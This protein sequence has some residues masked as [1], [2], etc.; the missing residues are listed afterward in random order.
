[1]VKQADRMS[2][3]ETN[4][5]IGE[6]QYIS[7]QKIYNGVTI[8]SGSEDF[9][10]KVMDWNAKGKNWM[11][12]NKAKGFLFNDLPE[13]TPEQIQY[14]K[15]FAKAYIVFE[16]MNILSGG[17]FDHDKH[18]AQL[19]VD[20]ETNQVGVFDTGA[21]A[22]VTPKPEEQKLLGHVIYDVIKSN[23]K[24]QGSF[25]S[26]SHIIS[27]KID[28]LYKNG[29]NTQYLVEVKKGLLALG[30]FFKILDNEDIE[31][32]FPGL[33]ILDQVSAPIREGIEEKMTFGER[34]KLRVVAS[35]ALP[36]K[37]N[38]VRIIRKHV[39]SVSDSVIKVDIEATTQDKSSWLQQAFVESDND[40]TDV[41]PSTPSGKGQPS[42]HLKL[43]C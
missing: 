5:D 41:M 23:V 11:I 31:D 6:E 3:I 24:E 15:M 39:L 7:A 38:S 9:S 37:Q 18:G 2:H 19:C 40:E 13:K 35:T 32:I 22:L 33:D 8:G 28:E 17:K 21:M 14:K 30:D 36:K 20:E 29:V 42:S 43:A 12:M 4:H 16:V 25:M 10:L 1:M 34:A 27:N 26:F